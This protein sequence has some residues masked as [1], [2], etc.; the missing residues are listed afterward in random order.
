MKYFAT[1]ISILF[2]GYMARTQTVIPLYSGSIPNSI[3]TPDQETIDTTRQLIIGKV[4]RPTLTIYLPAPE[5]ATGTGVV[6]CPGGGYLYLAAAHEGYDVARRF[7]EM[8]IAAFVLKYRIPDTSTMILK[9]IGPLQDV[10]QAFTII[11][12]NAAEYGIDPNRLGLMGFSAGGHLASTG[13]THFKRNYLPGTGHQNLRPDFMILVYPVISFTD[14][15][16]H[17]GSRDRLIGKNPTRQKIRE[18]SNEMQ[19]TKKTP[20]TF[21]VHAKDDKTVNYHNSV[22]F[23]DALK[24]K[25]VPAEIYLYEKGGHG[26]GMNNPTSKVKWMDKAYDWLKAQGWLEKK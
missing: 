26:F 18:F 21:L 16:A 12:K 4:S 7:N 2:F 6:I 19:V 5:K 25:H 11:R 17:K 15:L 10:Q 9:E 1:I 13:G 23:Y 14:S 3:Q 8:G 24:R 20:P 22:E